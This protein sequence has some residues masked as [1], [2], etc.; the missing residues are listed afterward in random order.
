[1]FRRSDCPRCCSSIADIMRG[2]ADPKPSLRVPCNDPPDRGIR[3]SA[4]LLAYPERVAWPP[5]QSWANDIEISDKIR[6]EQFGNSELDRRVGL[7]LGTGNDDEPAIAVLDKVA[8]DLDRNVLAPQRNERKQRDHR[9]V[10]VADCIG[11][12]DRDVR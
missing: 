10:A 12:A 3:K 9:S 11:H 6:T 5:K 7:G 8:T 2:D 1:M 4:A